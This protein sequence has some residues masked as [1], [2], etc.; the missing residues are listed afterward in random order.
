MV[1]QWE[2]YIQKILK[3]RKLLLRLIILLI[4]SKLGFLLM[5]DIKVEE[6]HH[7]REQSQQLLEIAK[8]EV[9]KAIKENEEIATA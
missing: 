9:E 8:T 6:S 7:K 1:G 3:N 4:L 2:A 5:L